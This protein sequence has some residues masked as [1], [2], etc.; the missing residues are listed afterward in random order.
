MAVTVEDQ[1]S[2]ANVTFSKQIIQPA[3]VGFKFIDICLRE[4]YLRAV[5]V[6][7]KTIEELARELVVEVDFGIMIVDEMIDDA[8]G[9]ISIF[10]FRHQ[11]LVNGLNIKWN[12]PRQVQRRL[13]AQATESQCKAEL[14]DQY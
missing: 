9:Y 6:L 10:G 3:A 7:D 13:G 1:V 12:I 2:K 8:L 14:Q 4:I 5:K 11:F